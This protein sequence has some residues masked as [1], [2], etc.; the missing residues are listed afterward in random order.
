M[1]GLNALTGIQDTAEKLKGVH[2]GP[3]E[4][5]RHEALKN[6]EDGGGEIDWLLMDATGL[7]GLTTLKDM[8][9][10]RRSLVEIERRYDT[11]FLA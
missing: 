10:V 1:V 2:F 9:K 5:Q 8:R 7:I 4:E 6:W 3:K 11:S